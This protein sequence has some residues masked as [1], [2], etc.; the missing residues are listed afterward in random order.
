MTNTLI[1][2][3][4]NYVFTNDTNLTHNING[5][6]RGQKKV[7]TVY[8]EGGPSQGFY[9]GTIQNLW[10]RSY[11]PTMNPTS[12]PTSTPTTN[13]SYSPSNIPTKS[14]AFLPTAS[15]SMMP[16]LS[17]TQSP[18]ISIAND[19]VVQSFGI[20]THTMELSETAYTINLQL[21]Y[22]DNTTYQCSITPNETG[23]D[24][25]CDNT[26][27]TKSTYSNNH[28]IPSPKMTIENPSHDALFLDKVYITLSDG[29]FYG[30]DGICIY[31]PDNN[32]VG[33][34]IQ[35]L[36]NNTNS[37][38]IC[39]VNTIWSYRIALDNQCSEFAPSKQMV[40]FDTT[41]PNQYINNAVWKDA[42]D[43][44]CESIITQSYGGDGTRF[45]GAGTEYRYT[46][47]GKPYINIHFIPNQPS[48]TH[49]NSGR[50]NHIAQWALVPNDTLVSALQGTVTNLVW[51]AERCN[52]PRIG[53][54]YSAGGVPVACSDMTLNTSH[55]WIDSY[56]VKY[57]VNVNPFVFGIYFRTNIGNE[58]GCGTDDES[59]YEL[60]TNWT[61]HTGYYLS[62]FIY[63]A[64][65]V[66]DSI[67]FQFTPVVSV[68][69]TSPSIGPSKSPTDYPT[70]NPTLN[71]TANPTINPSFSPSYFPSKAPT[72]IPSRSPSLIPSASPSYHPTATPT[73]TNGNF[74]NETLNL[75]MPGIQKMGYIPMK[76]I[77]E[78]SFEI[79]LSQPCS[80]IC[81]LFS[82]N[83][84]YPLIS[85]DSISLIT[86]FSNSTIPEE[87][88][89]YQ[90]LADDEFHDLYWRFSPN[91]TII[92]IDDQ[93]YV[94][95]KDTF[96]NPGQDQTMTVYIGT[97]DSAKMIDAVIQNLAINSTNLPTPLPTLSP[98]V[99]PSKQPT[100][101]L[102]FTV[103]LTL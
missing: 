66:I 53:G 47:Q 75:S 55:E 7:T 65:Q 39:G 32:N 16:S 101:D 27:W 19:S 70:I 17:P 38:N 1:I 93:Q 61:I 68:P 51:S 89:V 31:P 5:N 88:R 13:P 63:R 43:L 20:V 52:G 97:N 4:R 103:K 18:I 3:D 54:P 91:S 64:V 8:V 28:C 77:L 71:P 45:G 87:L 96:T 74:L 94:N 72:F 44:A 99:S 26:T 83:N 42:Y 25:N 24:Y 69:T 37:I 95:I 82:I 78:I 62:G 21:W 33:N 58:Y 98:S 10:I 40:L 84:Q 57:S 49:S 76:Q 81:P 9:N 46:N 35:N 86:Q 34:T 60:D 73:L 80:A 6:P 30:I 23:T 79:K 85:V 59:L 56:R 29:G 48:T 2:V 15:P 22:D 67:A 50:V 41:R 100:V 12:D 90:Y 102:D 36:T 11:N 92:K 14:P